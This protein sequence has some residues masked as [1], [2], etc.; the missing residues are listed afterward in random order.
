MISV[1][2]GILIVSVVGAICFWAIDKF[3]ERCSTGKSSQVARGANLSGGYPS[4]GSTGV[5]NWW[6][7]ALRLTPMAPL[8]IKG[9]GWQ[10]RLHRRRLYRK[11]I[12]GTNVVE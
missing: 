9:V 11:M 8:L 1:L 10:P 6:A 12:H 5:G 2:I 4:T 7:V 3:A